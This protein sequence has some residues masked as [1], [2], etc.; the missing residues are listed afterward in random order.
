MRSANET[1]LITGEKY[2]ME[3]I[4]EKTNWKIDFSFKRT[5]IK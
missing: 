5:N 3:G 1:R 4:A 2:R